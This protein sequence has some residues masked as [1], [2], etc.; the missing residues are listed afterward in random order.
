MPPSEWA[1]EMVW[2]LW[3]GVISYYCWNSNPD[4]LVSNPESPSLLTVLTELQ[5]E[6]ICKHLFHYAFL[7]NK[8]NKSEDQSDL[9]TV[10]NQ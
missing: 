7:T 6:L 8:H 5:S 1:P 2:V 10:V 9:F 4:H 3:G